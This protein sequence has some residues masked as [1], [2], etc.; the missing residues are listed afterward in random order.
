MERDAMFR[1]RYESTGTSWYRDGL[2]QDHKNN[3]SHR[4]EKS[5][6]MK[7]YTLTLTL[8]LQF[9]NIHDESNSDTDEREVEALSLIHI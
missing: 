3:P 7:F 8:T 1:E 2:Y 6:G 5:S 4:N 9:L